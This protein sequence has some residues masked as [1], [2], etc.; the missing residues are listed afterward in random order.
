MN[1]IDI[2]CLYVKKYLSEEQFQNIFYDY[3]DNFQNELEEDIY[4]SILST[5]FSSKEEIISLKTELYNFVLKSYTLIYNKINDS[6]VE[7][8][9]DS[10][11]GDAV[12]EILKKRY[13]KR[14]EVCIDCSKISTR[15]KLIDSI[16]TELGY[17]QTCGKNWAAI[18]DFIFDI[19]FP[20]KL[21]FY[22]WSDME[23]KL[24]QDAMILKKMLDKVS[25]ERC[26]V[27]YT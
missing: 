16:K 6:Y 22:N 21:I 25:Y 9:V 4:L 2:I 15:S 17:P 1:C 12:V 26:V 27:I 18:E 3:M 19:I 20:K 8:L 10:K 24:P 23:K 5:N 13:E 14:E 11:K 7:H